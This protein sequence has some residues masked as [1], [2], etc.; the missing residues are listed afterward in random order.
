GILDAVDG[1]VEDVAGTT[2]S[3][4]EG[5]AILTAIDIGGAERGHQRLERVHLLDGRKVTGD[6]ADLVAAGLRYR[7]LHGCERFHPACR[8]QAPAFAD[9]GPVE[10]LRAQSVPDEAGLVGDPLLVHL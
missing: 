2:G 7:V 3:R 9:I 4:V 1:R 10:A 5:C 6:G 8:L